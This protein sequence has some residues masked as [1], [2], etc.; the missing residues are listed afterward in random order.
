MTKSFGFR[1]VI[2]S[3]NCFIA[4]MLSLWIAF[5]LDLGIRGGRW[6]RSIS[7]A[8]RCP[9]QCEPAPFI[10]SVGTLLGAIA[11]VVIVPNL[12]DAPELTTAAIILWVAFCLYVSLLDR[13]PRAYALALSGYTAALVGFPSVL[14]P[15]GVFDTAIARMEEIM[16]GTVCA[17]LAHS[18]I[19]PRSVLSV[20]LAKQSGVLADARRWIADGL[21]RQLAPTVDQEQRR[22]AADVTELAILGLSLPYDTSSQRPSQTV[23]R[24]LDERLVGLLPLLSTI[25]DRIASLQQ[26]GTL[27]E[28]VRKLLADAAT[29]C[30]ATAGRWRSQGSSP[31]AASLCRGDARDRASIELVR[32][33]AS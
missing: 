20:L 18:I 29:W 21:T 2:F 14:N 8:S 17:A 32:S 22:I 6:S 25:E 24:A 27:P 28:N 1:E 7:P 12:V 33:H 4:A 26:G 31:V 15:G 9:G 13:T 30:R 16:L 11:M 10:A 5:R 3:V 23:I 19:F